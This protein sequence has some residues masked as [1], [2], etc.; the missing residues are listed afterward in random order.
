MED[1]ELGLD[2]IDTGAII[3]ALV[4]SIIGFNKWKEELKGKSKFELS[5]NIVSTAYK[6]RDRIKIVR[7]PFLTA[8]EYRDR[9]KTIKEV[10]GR[11]KVSNSFYA[12]SNRFK[13]LQ[14]VLDEWYGLKIEAEALFDN[15]SRLVLDKLDS[16]CS[17]LW[18]AISMYMKFV[19]II[20]T[21]TT[22]MTLKTLTIV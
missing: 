2:F 4:L 6:I 17:D 22:V 5:R 1:I 8:Y 14:L 20:M 13:E 19:M 15:K 12:Y 9:K 21:I 3:V 11:E 7:N 18:V 16:V 10:E